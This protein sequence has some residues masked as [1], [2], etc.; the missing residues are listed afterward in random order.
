MLLCATALALAS[1]GVGAQAAGEIEPPRA[2]GPFSVEYPAGATGEATVELALTIDTDGSV[3]SASVTKGDEPFATA[4]R[5]RASGWRFSPALREGKPIASIIRVEVVFRPPVPVP[6]EIEPAPKQPESP[7]PQRTE[8]PAPPIEVVIRGVKPSPPSVSSLARTEVRQLPGA[9]GDPFRAIEVMPGVTP[10]VSGLPYFFVRGAPPGNVGYFLDGV[11]VPLL[12]HFAL[13]PSVVHPALIDR[14]DLYSGGYPARYGGFAGAIVAGETTRPADEARGEGNIRLFDA[15]ALVETPYAQ[16]RG[17]VL[18]GG[19]YSYTAFLITQFAPEAVVDYWDYQ[20]RVSYDV[21]PRDRLTGFVFGSYDLAGGTENGQ[22][23]SGASTEFHRVDLRHDHELGPER[24][25]RLALTVGY[26]RTR[27]FERFRPSPY[28]RDR[29]VAAR[30]QMSY[31]LDDNLVLGTGAEASLDFYDVLFEGGDLPDIF[32]TRRDL[33]LAAY[34]ELAWKPAPGVEVTPGLRGAY[35]ASQ[36]HWATGLDPRLS[37]AFTVTDKI[38]ILHAYGIA[39]Q[40]PSFIVPI[41][42]FQIADLGSGLQWSF[43]SS[44]GVEVILPVNFTLTASVFHNAFFNMNDALASQRSGGSDSSDDAFLRRVRGSAMGLE[45]W[46]RRRL[47]ERLGGFLTYTL[48]RSVR[49]LEGQTFL[50]TYDRTHVVNAALA[51]DLGRNWRAGTRFVWYS[52]RPH[53]PM[54]DS[55]DDPSLAIT[56]AGSGRLIARPGRLPSFYRIDLRLEKKWRIGEKGWISLVVE[57]LN[58]TLRK[59]IVFEFCDPAY[60]PPAPGT[61]VPVP[62]RTCRYQEIGPITVPSIGVEGGF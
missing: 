45:L 8:P 2:L 17:T 23:E 14:V 40:L 22:L 7:S 24:T 11:R 58:A 51:Y 31:R 15:G 38:R 53:D 41:P 37:A 32:P 44:A 39:H 21:G 26:D 25:N 4:A 13:G 30:D 6:A 55:A 19:R 48:S 29:V 43:Q 1:T 49:T 52:G 20:A 33:A 27:S 36:G 35:F 62:R 5:S 42:G 28:V 60:D 56:G 16:G 12:Y 18:L 46:V 34:G 47:T 61:S 3:R 10:I 9:F 59:E 57:A 54:L 50:S